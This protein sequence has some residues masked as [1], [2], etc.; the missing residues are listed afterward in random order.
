MTNQQIKQMMLLLQDGLAQQ[1]AM[2]LEQGDFRVEFL[3]F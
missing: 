1:R 2:R 3:E